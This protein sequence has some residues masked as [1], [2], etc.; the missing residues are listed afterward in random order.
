M[1]NSLK[2]IIDEHG[3]KSS[4]LVPI[5]VWEELNV[6]YRKLQKKIEILEGIGEGLEEVSKA[7]KTGK[8]LETLQ[9]FLK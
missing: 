4:V 9:D 8:K 5:K 6:N 1:E 7:R 3:Q 2:Y